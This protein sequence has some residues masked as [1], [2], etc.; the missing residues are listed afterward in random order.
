LIEEQGPHNVI[1]ICME[2]RLQLYTTTL[3]NQNLTQ[4]PIF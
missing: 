4:I 1:L 3:E 2:A